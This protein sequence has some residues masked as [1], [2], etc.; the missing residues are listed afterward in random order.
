MALEQMRVGRSGLRLPGET[1]SRSTP[2]PRGCS[3]T[4]C[5]AVRSFS[6]A[7]AVYPEDGVPFTAVMTI[8]DPR[9]LAPIFARYETKSFGGALGAVPDPRRIRP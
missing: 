5:M 4:W 9:G 2:L 8:A 1:I 6:R 7:G 3:S